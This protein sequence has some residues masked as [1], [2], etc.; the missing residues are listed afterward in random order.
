[1]L[2]PNTAHT[3]MAIRGDGIAMIMAGAI[4]GPELTKEIAGRLTMAMAGGATGTTTLLMDRIITEMAI[5]RILRVMKGFEE[6]TISIKED[7][8]GPTA[9]TAE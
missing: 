9:V 5:V 4:M 3:I 6:K 8:M 2:V 1:M 7:A